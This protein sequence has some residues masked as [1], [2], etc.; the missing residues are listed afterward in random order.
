M[1]EWRQIKGFNDMYE[2]SNLGRVK[3]NY[4]KGRILKQTYNKYRGYLSVL[5]YTKEYSKRVPVHTIVAEYFLDHKPNGVCGIVVDHIDNDKL[6]NKVSNLQI[7]TQRENCSKD[8]HMPGTTFHKDSGKWQ[9]SIRYKGKRFYLGH[10][11]DRSDAY[12][13]Y[14]SKRKEL[15]GV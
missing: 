1:E 15:T 2:V 6:N 12:K 11:H 10:Y 9:A 5:L 4:G 13:A 14:L 8:K 3:S 7:I